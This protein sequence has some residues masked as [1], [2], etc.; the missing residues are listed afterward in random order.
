MN[1]ET[2]IVF[3][4]YYKPYFTNKS[5]KIPLNFLLDQKSA[6]IKDGSREEEGRVSVREWSRDR[7][8]RGG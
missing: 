6:S 3:S 2:N 4:D 5:V 1:N 8:L 7:Q